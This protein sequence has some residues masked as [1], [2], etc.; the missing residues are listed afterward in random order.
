VRKFKTSTDKRAS[1]ANRLAELFK[2][3]SEAA[4]LYRAILELAGELICSTSQSLFLH[5]EDSNALREVASI[6]ERVDLIQFVPFELGSGLSA[7]VGKER[8]PIKVSGI[9]R[10][11]REV[12]TCFLAAPLLADDVLVGVLT[13]ANEGQPS[14]SDEDVVVAESIA[15]QI[16]AGLERRLFR[17][18]TSAL[19]RRVEKLSAE[20]NSVR[21]ELIEAESNLVKA[22]HTLSLAER[23]DAPLAVLQHV[24]DYLQQEYSDKDVK[25]VERLS[26]ISQQTGRIST[27]TEKI[28][29]LS[30]QSLPTTNTANPVGNL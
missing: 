14:Y 29:R 28:R 17:Q 20:L 27:I 11:T 23:M 4:E 1:V 19:E 24:L 3:P 22:A 18:Q 7:W 6:G 2:G 10:R 12:G 5:D 21:V 26:V 8:R 30:H 13:F 16:A 15:T 25:L 9:G